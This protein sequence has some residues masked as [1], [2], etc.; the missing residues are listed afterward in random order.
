MIEVKNINK[1][2]NNQQVLYDISSVFDKGKVNLIT[3]KIGSQIGHL[4]YT[5]QICII[6][7]FKKNS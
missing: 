7:V 6:I 2:F 1:S 3:E 4:Q 5:I